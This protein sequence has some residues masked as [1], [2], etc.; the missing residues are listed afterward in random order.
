MRCVLHLSVNPGQTCMV[1]EMAQARGVP[2][3]FL[4]KILQK[5]KR[6]NIVESFRGVKG[7]FALA[8]KP[9]DISLLDVIEAIQG[10]VSL[11]ICAVDEKACDRSGD[12]VIHPVWVILREDFQ[13]MLGKFDFQMLADDEFLKEKKEK[14]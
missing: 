8:R 9:S 12:C 1:E 5:L 4:A 7:G 10:V 6:A 13:T 14:K 3:S 11:N 2:R